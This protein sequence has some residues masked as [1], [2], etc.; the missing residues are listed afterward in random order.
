MGPANEEKKNTDPELVKQAQDVVGELL[1]LSTCSRPDI[2]F[3]VSRGA[4]FTTSDPARAIR[5]AH[6]I[7]RYLA[8]TRDVG[9]MFPSR[10][11]AE[12]L[13]GHV[14]PV[15]DLSRLLS[16]SDASFAPH[17]EKSHGSTF[18]VFGGVPFFVED[19]QAAHSRTI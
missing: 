3:A 6:K 13:E 19:P 4:S 15:S 16:Y 7:L 8:G 10:E 5:I 14:V 2:A 9:L 12:S 17:G 11:Y 1:R 18:I